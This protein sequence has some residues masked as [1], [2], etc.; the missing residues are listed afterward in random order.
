M[1]PIKKKSN[2]W[3]DLVNDVFEGFLSPIQRTMPATNMKETDTSYEIELA[4]PG[5]QKED[6]KISIKNGVI[7]LSNE[8]KNAKED[9]G[10][11]YFRREF[12]YSTFNRSFELPDNADSEGI[13]AK[14]KDG[15]LNIVIPK[16]TQSNIKEI[17][18]K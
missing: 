8:F 18:I 6:L 7:T 1:L 15:I 9:K 17:E 13:V 16:T 2:E 12:N 14:L 3:V 4:V 11:N 10:E 5:M